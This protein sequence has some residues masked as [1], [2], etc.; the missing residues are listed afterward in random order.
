MERVESIH[1]LKRS[2][3]VY[4]SSAI[5]QQTDFGKMVKYCS[6]LHHLLVSSGDALPGETFRLLGTSGLEAPPT[7]G[8]GLAVSECDSG[9]LLVELL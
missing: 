4:T 8:C 1:K 3:P 9:P 2:K 5:S 6:L 7:S